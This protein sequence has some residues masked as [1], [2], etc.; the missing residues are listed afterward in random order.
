MSMNFYLKAPD[1]VLKERY[2]EREIAFADQYPHLAEDYPQDSE[3]PYGYYWV[4]GKGWCTMECT[5]PTI[6]MCNSNM[7]YILNDILG[8]DTDEYCGDL[9]DLQEARRKCMFHTHPDSYYGIEKL[10]QL[11][12]LAIMNKWSIYYA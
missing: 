5:I 4:D 1:G 10:K 2:P 8:L 6:N 3:G 11:I 12:D 7:R 9:E